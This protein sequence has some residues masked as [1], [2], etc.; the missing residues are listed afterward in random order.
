[1]DYQILFNI[2]VGMVGALGGWTL[3]N[4]WAALRDLQKADK[5]LSEKVGAI[6]VLV[7]GQ[8]VTREEFTIALQAI[9]AKLDKIQDTLTHKADRRSSEN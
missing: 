8:Y 2:V 1:M 9:F 4:M 5:E 6:E 3:N 7:A